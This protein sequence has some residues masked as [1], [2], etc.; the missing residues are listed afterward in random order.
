VNGSHFPYNH[1]QI[2]RAHQIGLDPHANYQPISYLGMPLLITEG[3][4]KGKKALA[5]SEGPAIPGSNGGYRREIQLVIEDK[6]IK[7]N[8]YSPYVVPLLDAPMLVG[9]DPVKR[10]PMSLEVGEIVV[11]RDTGERAKVVRQ[12]DDLG[13]GLV[14]LYELEHLTGP[15]Q[16]QRSQL[17]T[18]EL[19]PLQYLPLPMGP[20]QESKPPGAKSSSSEHPK[21]APTQ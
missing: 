1:L 15:L 19:I 20:S 21:T 18:C 3:T 13:R 17:T 7:V 16:G 14:R 12:T 10:V 5:V 11:V 6:P 2:T 8:L 9:L 4:F